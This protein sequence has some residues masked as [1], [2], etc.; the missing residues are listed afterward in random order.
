[1]YVQKKPDADPSWAVV[2]P[3]AVSLAN[4]RLTNPGRTGPSKAKKNKGGGI[5]GL[6]WLG[7]GRLDG[8]NSGGHGGGGAE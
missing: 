4:H 3:T 1:M 5:I 7:I 6:L 2:W 8:C